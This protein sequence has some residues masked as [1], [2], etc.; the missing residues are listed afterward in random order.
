[1]PPGQVRLPPR[2]QPGNAHPLV[3]AIALA[4]IGLRP[5]RRDQPHPADD[6]RRDAVPPVHPPRLL[7]RLNPRRV[8]QQ[9]GVL[10]AHLGRDVS[11]RSPP[12]GGTADVAGPDRLRCQPRQPGEDGQDRPLVPDPAGDNAHGDDLP[13]RRQC[14]AVAVVDIGPGGDVVVHIEVIRL[15]QSGPDE[16]AG[17]LH[18]PVVI[19]KDKGDDGVGNQCPHQRG[20]PGEAGGGLRAG[21]VLQHGLEGGRSGEDGGGPKRGAVPV[22]KGLGRNRSL[23]HRGKEA[24]HPLRIPLSPC[25]QEGCSDDLRSLQKG[26]RGQRGSRRH[27]IPGV[28]EPGPV[29]PPRSKASIRSHWIRLPTAGIIAVKSGEQE[30]PGQLLAPTS[31]GHRLAGI[32]PSLSPAICS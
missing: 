16:V 8:Q 26:R 31:E 27:R 2:L 22:S 21:A 9:V 18:P 14:L 20:L 23:D 24:V 6:M 3:A 4:A 5:L 7:P 17:T 12:V 1:M 19:L 25:A 32:L 28:G 10:H 29:H 30:Q 11:D 15:P 13:L